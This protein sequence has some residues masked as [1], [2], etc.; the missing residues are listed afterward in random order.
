MVSLRAGLFGVAIFSLTLSLAIVSFGLLPLLLSAI[1]VTNKMLDWRAGAVED[2]GLMW[3]A[4]PL[5]DKDRKI[6]LSGAVTLTWVG[7]VGGRALFMHVRKPELSGILLLTVVVF[8]LMYNW[9]IFHWEKE[10]KAYNTWNWGMIYNALIL[11]VFVGAQEIS[12][13]SALLGALALV[14]L[15]TITA[16]GLTRLELIEAKDR[17]QLMNGAFMDF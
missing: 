15:I 1:V 5:S 14:S 11:I 7:L 10:K 13:K 2:S 8:W 4:A 3:R 12:G 16:I 17:R 6:L 9:I